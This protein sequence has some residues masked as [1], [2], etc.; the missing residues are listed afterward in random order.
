MEHVPEGAL[1]QRAAAGLAA[2]RRRRARTRAVDRVYGARVLVLVGPG[3]Q[4]RRRALGRCPAGRPRRPGHR[5]PAA[6]GPRTPRVWPPSSPRAVGWSRRR[7]SPTSGRDLVST[8]S[9][10]SAAGPVCPRT[11]RDLVGRSTPRG[12]RWSPSTCRPEWR[13]TPAPCPGSRSGADVTVTFGVPKVCHLLEPARE[14]LPV[15]SCSSTSVSTPPA[16]SRSSTPGTAN[17]VADALA[18]PDAEQRQVRQGRRRHRLRFGDLPR[19]RDHG[20]VRRGARRGRDGAVPG[21]GVRARGDHHEPAERRL[22]AR[23]RPGA[24]ARVGLEREVRR[25]AF[26]RRRRRL[27][28]ARG[29]RRRRPGVP[30][31]ADAGV[32]AAHPARRRAGHA[33]RRRARRGRGRPARRRPSRRRA[34]RR[35]RA[36]QGVD[37][38]RRAPGRTDRR[39]SPFPARP[40]RARPARATPSAGCARPC[41]PP[42]GRPTRPRSWPPRC[43]RSR[44]PRTPARCRR[45]SSRRAAPTSSACG[46]GNGSGERRTSPGPRPLDGPEERDGGH[47]PGDRQRGDRPGRV[48]RQRRRAGRARRRLGR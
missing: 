2:R 15:G 28:A 47:R 12:S 8:A 19:R 46:G 39:A 9:S 18:V 38:A 45:T 37:A 24:P 10:A 31:G 20:D 29:A 44:R 21:P 41:S 6:W 34:H 35:D 14:P 30:A 27:R 48:P 23:P 11:W 43:R 7:R 16:R 3:Q 1:M 17:R 22:R 36:A 13:P 5:R 33:A 4:R 42:G 26:R 25:A 32:L 40:G